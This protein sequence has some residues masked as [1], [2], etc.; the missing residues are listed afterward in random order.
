MFSLL[1]SLFNIFQ[2]AFKGRM[3][4]R[5]LHGRRIPGRPRAAGL[6][7]HRPLASITKEQSY[8]RP[9]SEDIKLIKYYLKNYKYLHALYEN[10]PISLSDA[11]K[12][13]KIPLPKNTELEAKRWIELIK[14]YIAT[15]DD[16]ICRGLFELRYLKQ[17]TI[18]AAQLH[19]NIEKT[20]YFNYQSKMISEL[21]FSAAVLG[22]IKNERLEHFKAADDKI[23]NNN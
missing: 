22:L 20:T 14:Q 13:K 5:S 10:K 12:A 17:Y 23:I 3:P 9:T 8:M 4:L 16:G 11:K 19:L 15:C 18:V 2:G 7:R 21:Y 6:H 1:T